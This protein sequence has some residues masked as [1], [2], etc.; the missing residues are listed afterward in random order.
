MPAVVTVLATPYHL[1]LKLAW[2]L[3]GF[4]V[5]VIYGSGAKATFRAKKFNFTF[6]G[7]DRTVTYHCPPGKKPLFINVDDI[8]AIYQ[9]KV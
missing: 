9:G 4:P 7:D 2:A 6:R 1:L 5:T 3:F 8:E